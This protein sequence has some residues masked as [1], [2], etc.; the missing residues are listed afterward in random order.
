M[1]FSMCWNTCILVAKEY[2]LKFLPS[3][4]GRDT[5]SKGFIT[6][7]SADDQDNSR[8]LCLANNGGASGEHVYAIWE[9]V[10]NIVLHII[11]YFGYLG[12]SL[13]SAEHVCH[14]WCLV[15]CSYHSFMQPDSPAHARTQV[16]LVLSTLVWGHQTSS[17]QH[18]H[19]PEST[20]S[21]RQLYTDHW[22]I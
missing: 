20:C 22:R 13:M 15:R 8:S 14:L 6:D 12:Q 5:F 17:L 21:Q 18:L 16:R 19:M 1:D 11:N 9:I 2:W 10:L 3:C 7:F 4:L